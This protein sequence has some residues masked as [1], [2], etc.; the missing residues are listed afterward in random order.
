M[1]F[2]DAMARNFLLFILILQTIL[3]WNA[4]SA[5]FI[6]DDLSLILRNENL[7]LHS[8]WF[9]SLWGE[10]NGVMLYFRPVFMSSILFDNALFGKQPL[11]YH[12]HSF[13]WH[14]F[15]IFL[16][17][18]ILHRKS[19]ELQLTEQAKYFTVTLFAFHPILSENVYW[20][21]ARNDSLALCFSLLTLLLIWRE[22]PQLFWGGMSFLF[23]L[24]SKETTLAFLAA[25][26]CSGKMLHKKSKLMLLNVFLFWLFWRWLIGVSTDSIQ[27]IELQMMISYIPNTLVEQFSSLIWPWP[28][29]L[30]ASIYSISLDWWN[31]IFALITIG[32]FVYFGLKKPILRF[33]IFFGLFAVALSYAPII[34]FKTIGD[35]YWVTMILPWSLILGQI[36]HRI[37]VV[38][39]VATWS[40]LI[41][42]RGLDFQNNYQFW[43]SE[44]YQYPSSYSAVH[45]AQISYETSISLREIDPEHEQQFLL[46]SY[47]LYKEGYSFPPPLFFHSCSA[48]LTVS[49]KINPPQKAL[50]DALWIQELGC[51]FNDTGL[52]LM[53]VIYAQVGNW[54]QVNKIIAHHP[55]DP[56]Y[57]IDVVEALIA[58]RQN[59]P[60]VYCSIERKFSSVET[61]QRQIK[62]IAP[63]QQIVDCSLHQ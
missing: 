17:F 21:S 14:L 62:Q 49:T 28:L 5:D 54:E 58:L 16:F 25:A 36:S 29:S 44:Y 45:F 51:A 6:F 43:E 53:A 31:W 59:Q 61:L 7:T 42:T 57:R 27:W 52:G 18:A 23:A 47:E 10:T 40:M 50:E 37:I 11:G 41:W 9:N 35:R 33:W 1:L 3:Y 60:L 12:I 38:L 26:F 55:Q 24:L 8:V 20:I 19:S 4:F 34:A 39:A 32:F 46:H 63:Q 56:Y 22:K 48:F 15:S 2:K 30:A 13:V